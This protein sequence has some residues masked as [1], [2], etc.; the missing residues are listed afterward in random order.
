MLFN[1][2]RYYH[3]PTA[4]QTGSLS[5]YLLNGKLLLEDLTLPLFLLFIYWL[6]GYY[7]NPFNRSR[8]Q[9]FYTTVASAFVNTL[10]IYLMLLTNDQIAFASSNY[11]MLA[12]LFAL[13]LS[14][15]Y[16]GRWLITSR[17]FLKIKE[18]KWIF[19]TIIIGSAD[20]A[21]QETRQLRSTLAQLGY[22]VCGYVLI[23]RPGEKEFLGKPVYS[24]DELKKVC[25]DGKISQ[26]ILALPSTT[27][28]TV[29][30][31][32]KRLFLLNI[33]VK[34]APDLKAFL[35]SGIHLN[36]IYGE[37]FVD[38]TNP[39]ISESTRNIKRT[40][41]VVA[42]SLA[43]IVLAIPF[44]V[45]AVMIRRSSS[46]PAIYRQERVGLH[47]KPFTIYKFR[48]MYRDSE[49]SGPQ[50]TQ[51]NDSRIT[52]MGHFMRKYRIDE[53]PQFW[54]VLKGDMSLVG[55]RP[56]REFYVTQIIEKAPYYTLVHQV[57]PGITSWGMVKFGYASNVDEMIERTQYD[58][59]YLSNMSLSIDFKILIH[60]VRT[61][62]LGKGK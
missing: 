7:N 30:Q 54:N 24:F 15:T 31:Y 57:R 5:R 16:L 34:I 49:A 61:V 47:R 33:P 52:P 23:D 39:R 12:T 42:S 25:D 8:L 22:S 26:I 14:L 4:M 9:E 10:L 41:D 51:N 50:L 29:L 58:L 56:E 1:V 27:D 17:R 3:I 2:Y 38:L 18:N 35:T 60:T 13:L 11:A 20:K 43:L 36:D 46:G 21:A 55:P 48:T 32:L 62:V 53:L 28:E 44:A 59:L 6:S 19:R 37:P 40:I 45:I